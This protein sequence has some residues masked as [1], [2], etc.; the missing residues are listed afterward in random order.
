MTMAAIRKRQ[1]GRTGAVVS[2]IGLGGIPLMRVEDL[3][4]AARLINYALDRGINFIDTARAYG[5]S[6]KK[7]GLVMKERRAEVFLASKTHAYDYDTA[8]RYLETSL[9]ELQTDHLDL[10]QM[11]DISTEERWEAIFAPQ[12]A[13]RAARQ[14]QE[15]GLV[16]FVGLSGHNDAL[17]LRA[18]KSGEFDTVLLVYNLAIHSAAEQVIPAAQEY[19]VG[20]MVMKPL[21]GGIFFRRQE[22]YVD[23]IKALHFVLMN[24]GISV[25]CIG[26]ENQRDIDQAVQA[27]LSFQP[28]APAEIEEM[29]RRVRFLGEEV[30]RD[31]GY[32]QQVCP[33]Q[34]PIPT[35]MHIYDEARVFSYEWP[36]FRRTYGALTTKADACQDCGACEEKC[37]FDLKIRER[38]K[39]VHGQFN[40][41]V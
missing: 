40:Q 34:I 10:W 37:P 28:L 5:D 14:A 11:H 25:A 38:L 4:E 20:V 8:W 15:Q 12:G 1:L 32:C 21:S 31:C 27:S 6:E 39:W 36:R 3:E 13:M 18:V 19:Q 26:F 22:T 17:L 29:V 2:E 16:R 41:P 9:S 23:P 24:E 33:A 7:F 35:I 30:C